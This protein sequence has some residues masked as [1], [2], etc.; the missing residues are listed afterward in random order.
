MEVLTDKK[1]ALLCWATD[2]NMTLIIM[3]HLLLYHNE[4]NLALSAANSWPIF[5]PVVKNKFLHG[6]LKE[7]IYMT[8]LSG[9]VVP[10]TKYV[11]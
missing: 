2:M 6:D 8:P 3:K 7:T 10:N 9:Y 11:S 1:L 5:Q 4:K